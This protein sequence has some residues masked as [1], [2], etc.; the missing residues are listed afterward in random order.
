M[1]HGCLCLP[2]SAL[3]H[4]LVQL[5]REV[6]VPVHLY[7]PLGSAILCIGLDTLQGLFS[8]AICKLIP[9]FPKPHCL[10]PKNLFHS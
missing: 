3:D 6:S 4:K 2:Q 10:K 5:M 7:R 8:N 9:D 1:V